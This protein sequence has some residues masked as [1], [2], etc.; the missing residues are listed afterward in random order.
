M[1]NYFKQ[2]YAFLLTALFLFSSCQKDNLTDVKLK[3][4]IDLEVSIKDGRLYFPT[5]ES[6]QKRYEEIKGQG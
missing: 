3:E 4:G 6:F 5:L 1:K 2:W